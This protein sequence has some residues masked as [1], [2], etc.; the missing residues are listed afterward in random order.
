[1]TPLVR[2]ARRILRRLR[3]ELWL[4]EGREATSG[5]R[6]SLVCAGVG[7]YVLDLAFGGPYRRRRLGR[8]WLWSLARAIKEKGQGRAMVIIGVRDP[9]V[10]L[11]RLPKSFFIPAWVRGEVDLP[12]G[13]SVLNRSSVKSDLRRIQNNRLRYSVTK[14]PRRFHEFYH[15]MYVP[16]ISEI[17][18]RSAFIWPYEVMKRE[19]RS[20]ELLVVRKERQ[21]V[22]GILITYAKP[23]PRLWLVGVIDADR[24]RLGEGAVAALYYYSFRH[25]ETNGHS[26]VDVGLSRPFLDDG[27]LRYKRKWGVRIVG[28]SVDWLVLKLLA[29]TPGAHGFLASHPFICRDGAGLSGAI[30]VEPGWQAS[31]GAAKSKQRHYAISGLRKISLYRIRGARV[32]EIDA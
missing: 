25:L 16:Y 1:M 6:L 17:H 3:L 24:K 18:G 15:R 26:V 5:C 31:P 32:E 29:S 23:T 8:F 4:V 13:P 21:P 7:A 19:F 9:Y 27:V 14:D 2:R 22:S 20:C 12:L 10:R 28:T 11:V 30:F